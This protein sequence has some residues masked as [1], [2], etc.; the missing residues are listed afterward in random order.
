MFKQKSLAGTTVSTKEIEIEKSKVGWFYETS[1]L[2]ENQHVV[3][4]TVRHSALISLGDIDKVYELMGVKPHNVLLSKESITSIEPLVPGD[5]VA[6]HT[7]IHDLY[8]QQASSSPMG[9]LTIHI[10]GHKNGALA[11]HAERVLAI[12]GGFPRS[13]S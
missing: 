2:M 4:N 12:R 9:F 1:Y 6:I 5:K 7:Q 13:K 3:C 11:F 8:E 10:T